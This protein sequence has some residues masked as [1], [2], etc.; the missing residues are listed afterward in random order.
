MQRHASFLGFLGLFPFI[1]IPLAVEMNRLALFVAI[2]YFAQYSAIILSFLGGVLW[3]HSLYV[4][5]NERWAYTAMLPSIVGWLSLVFLP[6]FGTIVCLAIA[7][8]VLLIVEHKNHKHAPVVPQYE[9]IAHVDSDGVSPGDTLADPSDWVA[10]ATLGPTSS[11]CQARI[12]A[13]SSSVFS[14]INA[15]S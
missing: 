14:S 10:I 5:E 11:V 2:Q 8:L 9:S 1:F 6:P 12:S 7:L 15:L 4:H 3:Y 13:S